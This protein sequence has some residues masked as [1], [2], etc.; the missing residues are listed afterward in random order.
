[1][2]GLGSSPA[3]QQSFLAFSGSRAEAFEPRGDSWPWLHLAE[4]LAILRHKDL[5]GGPFG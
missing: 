3:V 4:D 1:M 5:H 2:G